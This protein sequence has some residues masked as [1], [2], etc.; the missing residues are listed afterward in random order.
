M[1]GSEQWYRH[2]EW[3]DPAELN[4]ALILSCLITE[5]RCGPVATSAPRP[6]GSTLGV[7]R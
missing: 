4:L 2:F 3:F 1:E 5:Q 7:V 6:A